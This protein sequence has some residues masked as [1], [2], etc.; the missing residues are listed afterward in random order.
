MGYVFL[1]LEFFGLEVI[2]QCGF[3]FFLLFLGLFLLLDYCS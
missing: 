3:L 1:H 2:F